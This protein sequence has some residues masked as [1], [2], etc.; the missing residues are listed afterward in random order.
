[1]DFVV[2]LIFVIV[3]ALVGVALVMLFRRESA[4]PSDEAAIDYAQGLNCLLMGDRESALRKLTEAVK[5]NSDNI[6]AYLKIGDILRDLGRIEKAINVHKYLTVRPGLSASQHEDILRSLAKDYQAAKDYDKA[7][8]V[9]NQ[10]LQEDGSLRWAREMKLKLYEQKEEW[11]KAF[12]VY[13]EF[14]RNFKETPNGRLALYKV[15]EGLQLMEGGKAKDGQSRFRDAIKIDPAN[16]AGYLCLADALTEDN[17]TDDALKVLRDFVMKVP[18][19]SYLA[20]D[21]LQDLLYEGGRYGEIETLY[22]KIIEKQ[23]DNLAARLA[24][25]ENYEKKGDLSQA[26]AACSGVLEKDPRNELAKKYLVRLYH[27]S[28]DKDRAADQALTLVDDAL[29]QK[30]L[31]SCKACEYE[32]EEPFWRCPECLEWE[33]YTNN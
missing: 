33:T 3:S 21:R 11:D 20:F 7:L 13:K 25:V 18:A 26:I 5:K 1:M 29:N 19:Q 23:P 12:Q 4:V 10:I 28:G 15:Q 9:L 14:K 8:G 27:K 16:P 22:H 30:R 2:L 32:A 31:F 6:D 17:R 24:L